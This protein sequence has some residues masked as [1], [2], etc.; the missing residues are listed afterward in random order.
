M[1]QTNSFARGVIETLQG[2]T[3]TRVTNLVLLSNFTKEEEQA[4]IEFSDIKDRIIPYGVV[5]RDK[6][7]QVGNSFLAKFDTI[8][9]EAVITGVALILDGSLENNQTQGYFNPTGNE[10]VGFVE[11]IAPLKRAEWDSLVL[12]IKMYNADA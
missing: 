2:K 1:K 3:V 11:C 7:L 10:K 9:S 4:T 5:A 8:S 12:E 6:N